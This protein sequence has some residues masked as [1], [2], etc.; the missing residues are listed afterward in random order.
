MPQV[1][2]RSVGGDPGAASVCAYSGQR[3]KPTRTPGHQARPHRSHLYKERKGGPAAR[4][5]SYTVNDAKSN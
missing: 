4:P 3:Q 5:A 2:A 1:H